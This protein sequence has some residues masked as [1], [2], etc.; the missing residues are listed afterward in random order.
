[1]ADQRTMAQLLQAPTEGY[2]DAIVVSAI[3]GDNFELKHGLLT[4]VQNKQFY[5][6]D[7]EDP[8]AHTHYFNKIT[9]TLKFPNVPNTSIKLMLFPFSLEGASRI[10]LEKEPPRSIFTWD[11]LVSKFINQFF[12]PSKMTS[13][14]NVITNFLQR[15]DES[16]SEAW[17]RFKDLF[18]A[19]PHFGF[20]ELH[21]LDTFY[22]ALNSKDQDSLNSATGVS[23]NAST[24]GVSPDVAE[25]KDMVKALLVDKKGQ[26]Q[27]PT[28]VKAVEESCV[29]CDGAHSYRNC[30]ATDANVYRDNIQEYVSQA[31]AVNYNQGNTGYHPQ[32]MSNQNRPPGFP[33]VPNN[34]NVQRNNQ[35]RFIPN[36]NRVTNLI[37]LITK[38]VNSNT[39]STSSSSTLPS[40]T[41]ANRK[42]DLKAINT[43]SGVSYDG[44][45]IPP[46][47]V[48][49][50][51]EA[52][53][54]TLNPTNNRNTEDVQPQAVQSKLVTSESALALVSALKPNPKAS[55]PYPSRRNNER[56]PLIGNKEKLSEIAR[57]PLNEHCSAVLLKKLP[58]K[59]GDPGKFL[60]PCDF[61]GMAECLALADLGASI[62][63]MPLS[64]WK[65]ISLPDLTPTCM[66]LKLADRSIFRPVGVAED[67]YVKVDR[68]RFNRCI[69]SDVI[70]MACEEY[71]QEVFGFSDTISSGN[72][73]LYHDPIVF[74]TSQT[75]TPFEN[76]DFLLEEVDAF[77]AVEDEPTSSNFQNYLPQVRKEL[78]ICE[79]KTKRSSVDEPYVVKLKALPPHLEYAFLEGDEK[80]PVII[81]KELSVEEKTALITILNPMHSVPKKGGLT[82]VENEDNELIQTRLVTGWR[83]CIDYLKLNEATRKGHFPLPFT[84]HMLERLA[85]NQYYYFLDGFSGYF[86]I[87]IDPKDQEKT[88]FTC[89]YRT[90]A[91][92]RMPFGLCNAPGMFQ[93]C[94]M[95]ILHDMIEK[96]MEV[97]MDDFFVFRNSFQSCLSHLEKMLKRKLTKAPILIALDWDMPFE[98]MFDA[99]DF[100]TGAVLGQRQDKYF[101]PIHYASKTMAEAKSNYTTTEKEMKLLISLRLATMDQPELTMDQITLPERKIQINELNKLRDQAY[102]NSLIYKEK[103]KRIHDSKIKNRVFN[104]G[105]RVLLFNSRLKIFSGK[106][107]SRWSGPFTVSQVFP[108][109]PS[110]Y[111]NPT[112]L[113]S[114]SM[115]IVSSTIL[116][117]TYPK[118][119][120]STNELNATYSVSTATCHSSQA[121]GSSS[122]ADELMFSFF[123]NQSSSPRL[124]N[125]DLEQIDQDDLEEMDL[126]WQV[127]MLSIRVKRFYKKTDRNLKF[128]GK[129]KVGFD[130]TKV[131]CFN[132]HRRGHFTRDC[133][134][135]RNSGNMSRDAR[136]AGCRGRNNGKRPTKEEDENALVIQ[137]RLGYQYGLES[138]EEQ[139]RVLQPNEVI[140]EEK[141][142]VLEYAVKDKNEEVTMNVF[143]NRSS[144]E[145][146][147]LANDRFKKGEGYHAVPPPLTGNY[148]PS[149]SDLSF[150]GLDDSIYKFKIS[151]T[152]TS[153]TKDEIGAPET[154][155]ACVDKPKEDRSSAPF[156]QYWDTK[157]D[158]DR[159]QTDK[160]AGP[161][162]TNVNAGTQ[163]NVDARKEV[164]DQHYIVLPLWSS[165]SFT[166]KSSNDKAAHDKPKDDIGLKTIEEPVNK[167]DQAY[168]DELNRLMGQEKEAS[169]ATDA[170]RKE[171]EQGCIDQ[172]GAT[173]AGSTNPVNTVSNPVNAASTS[174][175][176][177][178]SRPSS[179]H[180]DTFIPA[181][182]L[183]HVDQDDSQIP[184]LEETAELR[185]TGIFNSTYDD[186][187]DIFTSLVQSVGAEADF[188][189]MDSSTVV[190]PIPTHKVHINH[191]KTKYCE[192]QSQHYKQGG[193]KKRVLEHTLLQEKDIDYDG[194]FAPVARIEAIGI[195]LAFAS[196]MGFIVYQMD[197]K[198]AFLYGTIEEE[199]YVDDIIFGSTKKSLCDEF[200]AL[201][202]KRFQMSSIGELIFFLGLQMKQ[203]EEGIFISQD[204]SMIGSLMYLTTSRPDIMFAVYACFRFQVT[205]KLSHPHVVKRIIRNLKGQPKLDLWYPRDSPF[206]LEAY[207]D[208]DYARA[209]LDRKSTIGEYVAAAN[210]RGQMGNNS[211][212]FVSAASLVRAAS[213]DSLDAQQDNINIT[214]TQSK[215][216]LNEPTPYGEGLGSGPGRQKTM[217]GAMAQ[218]RSEGALIQ[219]IDPPLSTGYTVRSGEDMIEHDIELKDH[220]PQ[221][222]H[223]L[224]PSGGHTSGSDEGSMTLKK[225]T[226]LCTTL[227]QKV[228]DLENVKTAQAKEIANEDADTEIIVE[229]K[230]NGKKGGSTTEIVSTSRPD[231]SAARPEV[232][233]A[234]PKTPP[235]TTTVFDDEYVTNADTLVKMKNQKAKEKG[236]AF[237]DADDSA[238]PIRSITTLQPLPTIDPKDK[239]K[240]IIQEFE[241]VKKT[242]KK[243]QDQIE[244]DA[245]VAL[246][247]QAHLNEE[248]KIERERQEKAFNAALA[249]MYDKVQ[250]QIDANNKLAVRLTLEEQEKYTVKERSKLLAEFFERK[251][252]RLAKERA[253]AIRSKLPTKT[254]LRNLMMTYLKH[255]GRFTHAQL[256]SR[257][258]EEIHKLYIKK[259]KWVDTFVPIGS[260]ED[261]KIIGSRNKRAAGSISKHKSPKKQKVNDQDSEDSDKE[262]RKCDVHVYK[263]TRLDGSYRHFLTFSRMLE[264]LD[265]QDV[266]DLHKIIMK[267]FP[268]NDLEGYDLILWEDLNTLVESSKDDEIWRN[269]QDWKLLSWKLY[270]TCGARTLMLDD[271]SVSINMFAEKRYPLTKEILENMLS[272]RLE[273]ETKSTL[274]LDLIKFIKLQIE[275]K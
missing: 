184:D 271:S 90:F 74:A 19:C 111:H 256:K 175:T 130:K 250:A 133:R 27:S 23:T 124:D 5:R 273:A 96:T 226:Y 69:Q 139:S 48:E 76:S 89:P 122:Y 232:S 238:R 62:N 21:Q 46:L 272:P 72:P 241:P 246:K 245:E 16:F 3:T 191:L 183:L 102:E 234:E 198:S 82:I 263:L 165:I 162:D 258:F 168:R 119:T 145:E 220:V 52:T 10:W 254:K 11:D 243:D 79:A 215:A 155:T 164:S 135:A 31:S 259:Q 123:A 267:M 98:L 64:V 257:S 190:S 6:H 203:S 129:E 161:Q 237:K 105:D 222:P 63:L 159:N 28:P 170:L 14:R 140:Y 109:T 228:L 195:F 192:I 101:W 266:L 51:P 93:R 127:A 59:L 224:P 181:N 156:I 29:T 141:I 107:K 214:K 216:T 113:T 85:G 160:N 138:I 193:W 269:Q 248:A 97:F 213:T 84:D 71:S 204:K 112:G 173:N 242:K 66:T 177:S 35:N 146:N 80:L 225:L 200:E 217:G 128:N 157:S 199:V 125:E 77:L 106:L 100:A 185:S 249:K 2:E 142:R 151:E 153:L 136:N 236:I 60:I 252:K 163:D 231:I 7:K 186:K 218:I 147:S 149:K 169:D 268:A 73:T 54:D 240:G 4:L 274:A 209:N 270:E 265:R 262:H 207:L 239:G 260:E 223:D 154:S 92:R 143:D 120:S 26:S 202:H 131:E 38:F 233:T 206:D 150:A 18:R 43:R 70:G 8:H 47:V 210:W 171:S 148:M 158:N 187:L 176:F 197:V 178:D 108:T 36:Q 137:D 83:V 44:P 126:K 179:P 32:M 144:V 68:K 229:E 88:T 172:R 50:E 117:R 75:L 24:S 15:F 152:A 57:T 95:A 121:Q 13:L 58:E 34:Q 61:P 42:S 86:Q 196:F 227:L 180:Y 37:D 118:R 22:N 65:K 110:S 25:L 211:D 235:T 39:A 94:M 1:M 132:C 201:M 230:G 205:T 99:S 49:N 212:K 247:I 17:E 114:K 91:Y 255:T 261:E 45:Q 104:I 9:S 40:N 264:V 253:E 55:I 41:I 208:S 20:S 81:V 174:G 221:T 244:R 12:P 78:K 115:V 87:S 33:P 251:K 167:E 189:N 188:N 67:V 166:F 219:S 116:E 56:N 134:S 103:T 53:K 194:V 182:T 30:P 275:E